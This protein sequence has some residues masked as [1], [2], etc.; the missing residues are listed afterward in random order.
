MIILSRTERSSIII[1]PMLCTPVSSC[2]SEKVDVE[3]V[4]AGMAQW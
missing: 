4:G 2:V 3:D 1:G